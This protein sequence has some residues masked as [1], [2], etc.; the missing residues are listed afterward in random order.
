LLR[1]NSPLIKF[2]GV[3]FY[4]LHRKKD[5]ICSAISL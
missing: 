4:I 2:V 1:H 3:F 5:R